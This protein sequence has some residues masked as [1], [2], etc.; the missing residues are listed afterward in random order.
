[1]ILKLIG[2]VVA[3]SLVPCIYL[4]FKKHLALK[5]AEQC[6][7]K[8]IS[9]I[10][11]RSSKGRTNYKLQIEYTDRAGA[12]NHFTTSSASSPPSRDV[13]DEVVVFKHASG[14]A[15]DVLVFEELYLGYW[16]WFCVALCVVGCFAAPMVLR[17]VY[18]K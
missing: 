3:L 11:S 6:Q 17:F 5:N 14:S 4:A 1:M 13:G 9:H 2:F 8:V 10:P 12:I 7:G 18:M 16:M 15:P